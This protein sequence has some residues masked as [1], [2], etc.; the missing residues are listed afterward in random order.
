MK[1]LITAAA[2]AFIVNTASAQKVKVSEVPK[3][4]IESFNKNFAGVNAESWEK[5]K[6]GSYEAEFDLN[7]VETSA[8]FSP[9]GKLLERE[10]EI[11]INDLPKAVSDYLAKNHPGKKIKEAAKIIDADGKIKFEAEVDKKDLLF[12]EQGNFIK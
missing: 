10:T 6:D 8:T 4:V 1:N 5:E 12:D 11:S 9:D 2:F 7:K 3:P